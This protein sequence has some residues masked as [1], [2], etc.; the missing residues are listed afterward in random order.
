MGNNNDEEDRSWKDGEDPFASD[1]GFE[2]DGDSRDET[3]K[4]QS[5]E[6][7]SQWNGTQQLDSDSSKNRAQRGEDRRRGNG[8]R[9][10]A[11]EIAGENIEEIRLQLPPDD[12]MTMKQREK[13]E[14]VYNNSGVQTKYVRGLV[15]NGCDVSRPSHFLVASKPR[16]DLK[17]FHFLYFFLLLYLLG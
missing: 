11:R 17:I 7:Q 6:S 2:S 16:S 5:P 14:E 10:D 8:G 3:S 13:A 9:G 4:W 12:R 1:S 15:H